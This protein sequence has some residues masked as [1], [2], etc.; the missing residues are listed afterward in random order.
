MI[1]RFELSG[2]GG[3]LFFGSGQ[4]YNSVLTIHGAPEIAFPPVNNALTF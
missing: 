4:V 2:P 3:Y 1:I